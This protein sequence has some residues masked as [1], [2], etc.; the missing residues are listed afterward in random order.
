VRGLGVLDAVRRTAMYA[1]LAPHLPRAVRILG[2]G[3]CARAVRPAEVPEAAVR[4]YLPLMQLTQID[5]LSRTL[6]RSFPEWR[7][8]GAAAPGAT[9]QTAMARQPAAA[10]GVERHLARRLD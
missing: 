4:D 1:A 5:E 10:R 6:Q 2:A 9:H 3:L 7:T 8:V